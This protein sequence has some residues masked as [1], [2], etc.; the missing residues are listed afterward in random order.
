MSNGLKFLI[1]FSNNFSYQ[2][3]LQFSKKTSL[4]SSPTLFTKESQRK[5]LTKNNKSFQ[6]GEHTDIEQTFEY[7]SFFELYIYVRGNFIS[8]REKNFSYAPT[9]KLQKEKNFVRQND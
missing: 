1:L 5:K 9:Q 4:G 3:R 8:L 2:L 7:I 6:I